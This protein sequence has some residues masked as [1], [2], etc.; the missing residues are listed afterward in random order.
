[1]R[2]EVNREYLQPHTS[3]YVQ[4]AGNYY[5]YILV[6]L[7]DSITGAGRYTLRSIV[8][9][10]EVEFEGRCIH[11]IRRDYDVKFYEITPDEDELIRFLAD[12]Y[13]RSRKGN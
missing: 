5:N 10:N 12:E 9:G 8:K 2:V 1:M 13:E 4:I 3:Y 6:L 7:G 11:N